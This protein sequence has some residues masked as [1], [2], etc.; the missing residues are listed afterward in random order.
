MW[1]K[2]ATSC[3]LF[4]A[5]GREGEV[6]NGIEPTLSSATEPT[7]RKSYSRLGDQRG[8]SFY[9]SMSILLSRKSKTKAIPSNGRSSVWIIP[10]RNPAR[11]N[12]CDFDVVVSV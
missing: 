1:Q 7:I 8:Q 6:K 10:N 11:L 5:F 4:V 12:A 9:C 2:K 3:S